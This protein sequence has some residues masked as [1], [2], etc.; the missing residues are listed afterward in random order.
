MSIE[1]KGKRFKKLIDSSQIS[2]K[3]A[4]L[5]LRIAQDYSGKDLVLI[6]VLK[7]CVVF[8]SD[9]IRNLDLTTQI[10]FI[11]VSSY[12][13][14]ME[15]GDLELISDIKTPLKNRDVLLIEDLIDTGRTLEFI[16]ADILSKEPSSFK[17]CALIKKNKSTQVNIDIDYLGFEIG[18]QFIV[19]YGM[20]YAEKGRS[21]SDIYVIDS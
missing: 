14:A 12:K 1:I 6:G 3:V 21:L 4:E 8:M 5:A 7:G 18:D 15:S 10:D 17:I 13:N 20:D 19:G 11:H 2:T 16:R 9:L